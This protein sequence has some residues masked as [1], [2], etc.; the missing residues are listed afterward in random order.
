MY[1][2][3]ELDALAKIFKIP[4]NEL[5]DTLYYHYDLVHYLNINKSI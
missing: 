3:F 2:N 1:C 4:D 5:K